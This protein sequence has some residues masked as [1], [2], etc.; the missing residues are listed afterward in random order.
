MLQ[1]LEALVVFESFKLT[2]VEAINYLLFKCH[3]KDH[4]IYFLTDIKAACC[5]LCSVHA[6]ICCIAA[7]YG[8]RFGETWSVVND[9]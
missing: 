1:I 2:S 9:T 7:D 8:T 3:Q 4:N 6:V 5:T